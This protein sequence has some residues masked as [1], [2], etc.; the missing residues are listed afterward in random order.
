MGATTPYALTYPEQ[1]DP[2]DVALHLQQLAAQVD[3]MLDILAGDSGWQNITVT[4]PYVQQGTVTPRV[5]KVGKLVVPHWG[6]SA[7]GMAANTA[8]NV[9]VIPAGYRPS[10]GDYFPAG[11]GTASVV[12][13]FFIGTDGVVSL[14]TGATVAAG[15]Y[16]M[17]SKPWFID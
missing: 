2:V 4:A 9:G 1:T 13:Q 6:W 14:R 11:T 12:G 8:Y 17:L 16:F 7:Q 10:Q 5:R 3:D 15:N